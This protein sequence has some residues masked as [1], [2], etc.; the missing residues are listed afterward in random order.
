MGGL[1]DVFRLGNV[2]RMGVSWVLCL[3]YSHLSYLI[4][5]LRF[6][7]RMQGI[8]ACDGSELRSSSHSKPACIVTGASSGIGRA[9]ASA[10]ALR[11]FHVILAGRSLER[12]EVVRGEIEAGSSSSSC[13]ALELELCSVPSILRFVQR[14]KELFEAQ[15][16]PGTLQLLVNNAGILAA[17]RRW[18]E[19]GFDVM[20]ASNYLGP[21]ILTH[22]LL[23]LLQKN[24]PQARIVNLV[25]FTHRA[26]HRNQIDLTHLLSGGIRQN[27]D[28]YPL[29]KIYETSKLFMILYSYELHRQNLNRVSV[30]AADP[31]AVSTN[32]LRELP[33]GLAHLSSIVLRLLGL[34]QSSSAGAEAVV[35]AAL[36]PWEVSGKYVFGNH[37]YFCKSSAI[38]YDAQLG[39]RLWEA[40]ESLC[41]HVIDKHKKQA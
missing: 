38:T 29:A 14:V 2:L 5:R 10:L 12:L 34:L 20:T 22:E 18:T 36:V 41:N 25:S 23:P 37:G 35:A 26:S 31:G 19:D 39:R 4:L 1:P 15:D 9:T 8:N 11:G 17:S 27:R 33:S 30:M 3:I 28:R 24:A 13:Q 40:S 16:A 6:P 32:I 21:Y 7:H